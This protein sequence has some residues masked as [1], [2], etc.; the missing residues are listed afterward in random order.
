MTPEE[1]KAV[2]RQAQRKRVSSFGYAPIILRLSPHFLA[3]LTLSLFLSGCVS[4]SLFPQK[5]PLR[6]KTVQGTA[7]DKI[8]VVSISGIISEGKDGAPWDREDDLVARI[9]EELTLAADQDRPRHQLMEAATAMAAKT[10]LADIGDRMRGKCFRERLVAGSRGAAEFGH[11]NT[12]ALQQRRAVHCRNLVM[13]PRRGNRRQQHVEQ[14]LAHGRV[15][16]LDRQQPP[17]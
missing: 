13:R 15:S 4:L 5:M 7:A 8:L 3:F 9:K 1:K 16:A 10:A 12:V 11:G 14:G 2:L 6:E 17:F